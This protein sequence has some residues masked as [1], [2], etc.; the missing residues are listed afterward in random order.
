MKL[1]IL[2]RTYWNGEE[3]DSETIG[4]FDQEIAERMCKELNPEEISAYS[5]VYE[6]TE[7]VVNKAYW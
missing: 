5:I 7:Y 3:R 6:F 1:C 2:T 4:I